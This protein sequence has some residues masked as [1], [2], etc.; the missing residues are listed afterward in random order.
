MLCVQV[1][2]DG[3]P[4]AAAR[5]ARYAALDAHRDGPVLL[6]HTLD[7]QAETVLLGLGR[8]SGAALDRRDAAIRSAVVPAVAG[9]AARA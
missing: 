2:T 5:T 1:G 4:E 9:G 6:A 8:G 3:G 7:D